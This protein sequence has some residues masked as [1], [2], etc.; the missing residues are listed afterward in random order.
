VFATRTDVALLIP[1]QGIVLIVDVLYLALVVGGLL[2]F[3]VVGDKL[4]IVVR[5]LQG[6]RGDGG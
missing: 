5:G 6:Y 1:P 3:F 2:A 4:L